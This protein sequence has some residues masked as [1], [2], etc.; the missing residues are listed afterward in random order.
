MKLATETGKIKGLEAQNQMATRFPGNGSRD[1]RGQGERKIGDLGAGS[2]EFLTENE[3]TDN[4]LQ[5]NRIITRDRATRLIEGG[6][7]AADLHVHTFYS[8]DV[9]PTRE[10][11]PLVLYERARARGMSFICFTD[12][13]TMDAYDRVGWTREDLVTGVE[14][15]ILDRKKVGHTVHLNVYMLNRKQFAEIET[16]AGTSGDI[17]RLV[18]YLKEENL[19]FIFNHPFW[20]E[21]GEKLNPAAVAE[22]SGMF[23]VLEYNLGRIGKLNRLVLELAAS[24][25]KG[26]AAGTDSHTGDIGRIFTVARGNNFREFYES[27]K[28]GSA[29][30]V[31]EDLTYNRIKNEIRNRLEM[32]LN[33]GDWVMNKEGLKMETGNALADAVIET[34]SRG[35]EEALAFR[36]EAVKIMARMVSR[37]GLP[38][39]LYLRKQNLLASRIRQELNLAA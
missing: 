22:L 8:Y 39:R 33:S 2:T 5:S 7:Q 32:I 24:K 31:A 10:V 25:N 34:L 27:I 4:S 29:W 28:K 17:E 11:D 26:V 12:H 38:A 35:R 23:P 30:L 6:W 14:V 20:H 16:I 9:V 37:T 1:F 15:K 21:P 3:M 36:R 19:P 18:E 13:D